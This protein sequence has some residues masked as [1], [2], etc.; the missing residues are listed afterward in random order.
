MSQ[1][2]HT[3]VDRHSLPSRFVN[4]ERLWL[5]LQEQ[6]RHGATPGG[7]LNRLAFSPADQAARRYLI[8]LAKSSGLAV[9]GD[10]AGNLFCRL[11]GADTGAKPVLAGSYLDSQPSGGKFAGSFGIVAGLEALNAIARMPNKPVQP[12]VLAVW[13]NGEGSRFVP[14][15]MGSEAFV[16]QLSIAGMM[17]V[18][19]AEGQT[20]ADALGA[21]LANE[22]DVPR[23]P[24]G[25]GCSAY[26]E[27]HLEQGTVLEQNQCQ[28]GVVT[29]MQGIRRCQVRVFGEA[30]HIATTPRRRRR[31]ALHAAIRIISALDDFYS[32][33]DIGFAV[34]RLQVEPNAPSIVPREV[35]FS[36]DIRH[37]EA[38]V[39][40]RLGDTIRLVCES[41]KGPCTFAVT[42]VMHQ[43][44]IL[45]APEICAH[46]TEAA[47]RLALASM[48]ML[49]MTGHDARSL[50]TLCPSGIVF[51]PCRDG[52]SHSEAEAIEPEG[53]LAGAQV[54]TDVLWAL[55]NAS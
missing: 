55:A 50:A 51:I 48:P 23:C 6:A 49:S 33:P 9:S 21:V 22:T 27:A 4:G 12:I 13:S 45:L 16:G 39:L 28:I 19:D 7:G 26:L 15:Y 40:I 5:R 2:T 29:G 1:S 14:G 34:G 52:I 3:G 17:A 25:F 8:D 38:N 36:V 46:V 37:R 44:P 24:L 43:P 47:E 11:E 41:E 31:D 42:E 32:A 53:A 10:A 35:T 20:V 30:A 54:L 18:Q